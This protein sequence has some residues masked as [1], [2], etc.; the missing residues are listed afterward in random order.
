[1]PCNNCQP[2]TDSAHDDEIVTLDLMQAGTVQAIL[3]AIIE[4]PGVQD[5]IDAYLRGCGFDD[6]DADLAELWDVL[7]E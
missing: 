1:M 5:R 6:P 2:Q 7:H 3:Q 4:I